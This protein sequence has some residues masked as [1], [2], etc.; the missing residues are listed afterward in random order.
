MIF[1]FTPQLILFITLTF[2]ID[3]NVFFIILFT[4]IIYLIFNI[5]LIWKQQFNLFHKV[6]SYITPLHMME[7]I[8]IY[9]LIL[10]KNTLLSFERIN[11]IYVHFKVKIMMYVINVCVNLI[12][13]KKETKIK[14]E[15]EDDYFKLHQDYL[16]ISKKYKK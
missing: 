12:P 13:N 10:L 9:C 8:I 14:S 11:K 3:I 2:W 5:F 1:I 16:S 6:L 15:L 4:P 7:K